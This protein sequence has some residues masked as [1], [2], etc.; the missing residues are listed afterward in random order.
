MRAKLG[1]IALELSE[2]WADVTDD[3][4]ADDDPPWTLVRQ[5]ADGCGSFQFSFALY[6]GGAVPDSTPE[7]LAE[8]VREFG[9]SAGLGSAADEI[10]E[11]VPLQLAAATF[12]DQDYMI[13][14][15]YVS[16]GRNF[17]KVTYTVGI[18]DE[19][20]SEMADCERMVRSIR[21]LVAPSRTER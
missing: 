16:D 12:R 21:F 17:A 19:Y 7:G 9:A 8:L 3:L 11:S 15:W 13:R 4:P 10:T 1:P 2:G 6:R 20:L 5:S 18:G 14:A